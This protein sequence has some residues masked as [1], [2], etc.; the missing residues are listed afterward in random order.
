MCL[1]VVILHACREV[2]I[3]KQ[4]IFITSYSAAVVAA[5]VSSF[6]M[7]VIL[8][9]LVIGTALTLL[10][11]TSSASCV[12][13]NDTTGISSPEEF[14]RIQIG[15]ILKLTPSRF[16][17][18]SGRIKSPRFP[19]PLDQEVF[20]HCLYEIRAPKGKIIRIREV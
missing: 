17:E 2:L 9:P 14:Q 4:F 7:S 11:P 19:L 8:L 18:N 10:L 20:Y 3:I 15:R 16:V 1:L 5:F 13:L 12:N 6:S